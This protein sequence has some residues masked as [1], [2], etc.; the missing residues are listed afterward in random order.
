MATRD[1]FDDST[2][3][4]GDHLEALRI[5]L[6]KAIIG[7]VIAICLTLYYGNSIV[8]V[9]REPIDNALARY[10]KKLAVQ[11]MTL[12]VKDDVKTD[13]NWG[14]WLKEQFGLADVLDDPLP[15][16]APV[17]PGEP[18]DP[19]ETHAGEISVQFDGFA[20]ASQLH[21]A[22]PDVYPAPPEKLKEQPLNLLLKSTAFGTWFA[23]TDELHR[24]VALNVQEAFM[25]YIKVSMIAG[26]VL[27]SPWVFYQVWLFVAVGLYKHER[28][29]VYLYGALSLILFLAGAYFCFKAVFP[30]VLNFLLSFNLLLGITPQIRLSEWVS[31]AVM[32]PLMFGISF[33]LPLVM[34]FLTALNIFTPQI[35]REKRRLAILVIAFLSMVLTPADPMSMLLMMCPLV[36]LYELGIWLCELAPKQNPFEMERV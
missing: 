17:G 27:A 9:I 19:V 24:P 29:F 32:L 22:A 30:F 33:Q 2:M 26:F 8:D 5:H 15:G 13:V 34:R 4:F 28:K 23:T 3:S 20:L 6:F 25:T 18:V 1:L 31:F 10:G 21:A 7:F 12:D 35:Y 14:Q 36:L 11:G 16:E